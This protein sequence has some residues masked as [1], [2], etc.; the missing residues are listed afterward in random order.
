MCNRVIARG[1][2]EISAPTN[3]VHITHVGWNE[4]LSTFESTKPQ[5]DT[6]I[7]PYQ[8]VNRQFAV[9]KAEDEAAVT[10][11][12]ED[13]SMLYTNEEFSIYT[14]AEIVSVFNSEFLHKFGHFKKILIKSIDLP[15]P[16]PPPPR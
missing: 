10:K 4:Q 15:P 7:S 13:K 8:I 16:P 6:A 3:F 12:G 11:E 9:C 1:T 14:R 2:V 5:S